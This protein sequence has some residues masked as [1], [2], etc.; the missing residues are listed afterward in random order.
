M[1]LG[2][3]E[4]SSVILGLPLS[5]GSDIWFDRQGLAGVYDYEHISKVITA[6]SPNLHMSFTGVGTPMI[7]TKQ[8]WWEAQTFL[9]IEEDKEM[10][11]KKGESL[12]EVMKKIREYRNA[13][14]KEK[15]HS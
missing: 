13:P 5:S 6:T 12:N 7:K 11:A 8:R 9:K 10:M 14:S 15:K 4:G 3:L 1:L 2:R